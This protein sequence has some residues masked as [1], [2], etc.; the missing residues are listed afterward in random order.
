MDCALFFAKRLLPD[1]VM[2]YYAHPTAWNEI[3]FGGPA[4]PRGYVRMGFGRCDPWEAAEDKPGYEA[5]VARENSRV[6]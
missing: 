6:W 2:S 3:G 1:I 5:E 4:S